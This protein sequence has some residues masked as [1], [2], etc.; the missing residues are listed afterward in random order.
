MESVPTK[1][2][3]GNLPTVR[4]I[5]DLTA[6]RAIPRAGGNLTVERLI[7]LLMESHRMRVVPGISAEDSFSLVTA[8][9]CSGWD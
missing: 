5:S 2:A 1:Q 9:P 7:L 8:E 4:W 6:W 3:G